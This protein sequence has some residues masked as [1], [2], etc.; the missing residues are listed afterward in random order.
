ML[1][2]LHAHTNISDGLDNPDELV[3]MAKAESIA[4]L[5]ITDHDT[6]ASWQRLIHPEIP[7]KQGAGNR[8]S[9]LTL[10]PG[11]EISCR[12]SGGMSVH[13]LGYLFDPDDRG[14]SQMM[15]LTR[16][17]RVPRIKKMI[18]LLNQ[19]GIEVRFEDVAAH[20]D[21][22]TTVGRPHLADALVALGVTSSRNEAF[23]RFLHNDSPFYVGHLAPTPEEAISAIKSAGGVSVLAHG[24]AGS[25]GATYSIDEIAALVAHGLDGV[26]VEHR[27]HDSNARSSLCELATALDIFVTGSSDYHGASVGHRL[28]ME[29]TAPEVWEGILARGNGSEVFQV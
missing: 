4:V 18:A 9:C 13:M 23:T 6:V 14:L 2:D 15:A 25:R 29:V 22:A 3:A 28:A 19:A 16:D 27:D 21:A 24:L 20:S 5:A 26:E 12:T 1:I 7:G 17:D 10:V 8:E 11:A